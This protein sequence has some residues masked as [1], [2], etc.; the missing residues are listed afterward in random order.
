[1]TIELAGP[2]YADGKARAAFWQRLE[3]QAREVPGIVAVGFGVNVPPED[4][5]SVIRHRGKD[6][7]EKRVAE[8]HDYGVRGGR[9][10]HCEVD[11][12]SP[13]ATSAGSM[14][15]RTTLA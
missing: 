3:D 15:R 8:P 7:F 2:R 4:P 10:L 9:L 5:D 6:E 12:S 14:V 1:M 11:P 13:T